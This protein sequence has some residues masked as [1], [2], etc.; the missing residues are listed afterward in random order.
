VTAGVKKWPSVNNGKLIENSFTALGAKLVHRILEV[1]NVSVYSTTMF[2]GGAIQD[3]LGKQHIVMPYAKGRCFSKHIPQLDKHRIVSCK[4]DKN[5]TVVLGEHNGQYDRFILIFGKDYKTIDVRKVED[6][7]FD[8]INFAVTENGLCALLS[9]PTELEL[10]V[11]S[12]KVEVLND[13]PFDSSMKLFATPDGL[14]F[15]NGNTIHQIKK[16]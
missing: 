5:I 15:I 6:V 2:E 16:K 10:F 14:F 4:S 13:P 8:E 12:Q 11:N 1:E 9:S 7:A 3:L